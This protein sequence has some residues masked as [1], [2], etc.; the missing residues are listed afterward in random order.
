MNNF[1]LLKSIKNVSLDQAIVDSL[2]GFKNEKIIFL[3][4]GTIFSAFFRFFFD[5]LSL[6]YTTESVENFIEKKQSNE[7]FDTIL[8]FPQFS[9]RILNI[10]YH[11]SLKVEFGSPYLVY[12]KSNRTEKIVSYFEK[13]FKKCIFNAA[14]QFPQILKSILLSKE[15]LSWLSQKSICEPHNDAMERDIVFRFL[16][17]NQATSPGIYDN[18]FSNFSGNFESHIYQKLGIDDEIVFKH[19]P[20]HRLYQKYLDQDLQ[21]NLSE[22]K[23]YGEVCF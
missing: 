1:E 11:R 5:K 10:N 12:L 23:I 13:N 4:D 20:I 9:F 18:N 21:I 15:Y 16:Q 6:N 3:D 22:R 14:T 19:Y 7:K 17:E 2:S 8:F